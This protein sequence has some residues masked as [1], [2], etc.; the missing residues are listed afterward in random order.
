MANVAT[1][2]QKG[3][4]VPGG[5]CGVG[6]LCCGV[7]GL[8]DGTLVFRAS[9]PLGAGADSFGRRDVLRHRL[10]EMAS[11][12]KR[13][14][15]NGEVNERA[16]LGEQQAEPIALRNEA[17]GVTARLLTLKVLRRQIAWAPRRHD[18]ANDGADEQ[19]GA[20]GNDDGG[21]RRK[22]ELERRE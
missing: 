19:R 9:D 3:C 10:D 20:E 17:S 8:E 18:G 2:Q 14:F 11:G 13:V 7:S 21:A 15:R 4:V 16:R 22:V 1:G 12:R 5:H 6:Q